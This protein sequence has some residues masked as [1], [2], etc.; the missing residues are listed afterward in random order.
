MDFFS[1]TKES[2]LNA[3]TA[4]TQK[5]NG[6]SGAAM[7]TMKIHEQ[8]KNI[9]NN[10]AELGKLMVEQHPEEAA[11]L[12]PELF[13]SIQELRKQ[14]EK[15]KKELAVC[16]GLKICPN[17]GAEQQATAIRCTVCGMD[18]QEAANIMAQNQP[19]Q[20]VC[21]TCGAVVVPGCAFCSNCGTKVE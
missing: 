4:F 12:C 5:A 19:A 17:C 15:D 11:R 16:K 21:K 2:L 20:V 10:I 14:I 9:Q 1:K 8:E 13:Y 3:G 18:M 7:L 6:V